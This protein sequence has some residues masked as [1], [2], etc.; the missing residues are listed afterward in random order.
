MRLHTN[1]PERRSNW[2]S[3]NAQRKKGKADNGMAG[4]VDDPAVSGD[5]DNNE[6]VS[7]RLRSDAQD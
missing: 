5:V 6:L 7:N 1:K 4:K 3:L 2:V